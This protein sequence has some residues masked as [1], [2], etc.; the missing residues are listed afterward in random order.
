MRLIH[1]HS[2]ADGDSAVGGGGER[3]FYE[4]VKTADRAGYH[5][6]VILSSRPVRSEFADC[7]DRTCLV[8]VSRKRMPVAN[9]LG[10]FVN[11]LFLMFRS[12]RFVRRYQED[13]L[14][15]SHSAGINN[16]VYSFF[17]RLLNK[18]N[19]QWIAINHM[20]VPPRRFDRSSPLHRL[21]NLVEQALFF[22]LQR[23]ASCL[24]SV[25][26]VY[27]PLMR[28]HNSSTGII[29]LG[30]ERDMKTIRGHGDRDIDIVFI[31]RFYPQK[32]ID[33]IPHILRE[34]DRQLAARKDARR[35]VFRA[36][37]A[38][39]RLGEQ[40][41]RELRDLDARFD[42]G[43]LGF[44]SG[45]EKYEV[46]S[47]AKVFLF[48]SHFE[49]FGIVYLDAISVG[50]PVVEYDLPWFGFHKGGV[51][52]CPYLDNEEF[53]SMILSFV[54]EP[55]TFAA[56]ST[57]AWDYGRHFTWEATLRELLACARVEPCADR[58]TQRV[59]GKVHRP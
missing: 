8:Y 9:T 37:G 57:E 33:Q 40:L 48:P 46:L 12:L 31:G 3:C 39:N 11:I 55:A 29:H 10:G 13:I 16:V 23:R 54:T 51:K 49:S 38:M 15:V 24:V 53:A 2:C 21:H 59:V 36:V 47:R 1:V 35:L 25:N 44:K 42:I 17:L 27:L 56:A 4:L 5:Q 45:D 28:K 43:F 26:A 41:R 7:S 34:V 30:K 14:I 18:R 6:D 19:A 22:L 50:T 58:T 32:G 52:K 20:F